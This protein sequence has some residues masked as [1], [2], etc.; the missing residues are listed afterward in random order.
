MKIK[1]TRL[2]SL[3]FIG[4]F[5]INFLW[6]SSVCAQEPE[7][8]D[9]YFV[10]FSHLDFFWGGT[11]EECVSRGNRIISRA[12]QIADKSP[13][14]RF[15]LED[16]VF[17]ENFMSTHKGSPESS[18]FK[19]LVKEGRI[20]ISP[21]WV[22]I[23]QELPDGEVHVRNMT[24]GKRYAKDIFGV[25]TKVAHLGD[26]PGYTPQF[27]QILKQTRVPYA[28]I[29]RMG[30][31]DKSAFTWTSPD[32][33]GVLAWNALNGYP[34]GTFLTSDRTSFEEKK[35][36][37]MNNLAVVKR[38]TSGPVMM[39]WGIDLWAPPVDLVTKVNEFFKQVPARLTIS[40]PS[41][42]FLKLE[43]SPSLPVVSG[44]I[45]SSWPNIVSSLV[46]IWPLIIP[47]TNTLLAAEKFATINYS[48]GYAEYPQKDFDFLWK[49]LVEA[50]DHNHDGQGGT[51]GDNRKIEYLQ[52][53]MIQGGEILRNSLRNIAERV[54]IPVENSFPVVVFNPMGWKRSDIVNAHI[55][56]YGDVEPSD[57]GNFR[58]GIRLLDESGNS[59]PFY[60]KEWSENISR[61][62]EIVFVAADVPSVGYKTFYV[63]ST[64]KP[65]EFARNTVIKLD[66]DND[67]REPRRALGRDI[68]ENNFYRLTVDRAT[69]QVALFDKELNRDVC[70]GMELVALEERG[71]NYIGKEPPSGRTFINLINDITV[72]ENNP[73]RTII[74]IKGT[75]ADI[76]VTQN[77]ALYNNLKRLDI[78]NIVDWKASNSRFV[79]LRQVFPVG[80]ENAKINYGIP[81]GANSADNLMLNAETKRDDEITNESW[82]S[83]RLIH[84]WIHAGT[85]SEGL[86]ISSDHQQIRLGDNVIYAEMVRGTRYVS[87]KV[88]TDEILSSR[89]YPPEGVY[90]FHYSLSSGKGDWKAIKAYR[91]GMNF[92][93][94]LIPISVAD[95]L[96]GK[97]LPPSYSFCSVQQDNIIIST[98]KKADFNSSPVLRLYEIEGADVN[99]AVNFL[100]SQVSFSEV[101]MLEE[102][103]G[104]TSGKILSAKP[105]SISTIRLNIAKKK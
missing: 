7:K 104:R 10:P 2:L 1:S 89:N 70:N 37:F 54:Q 22:G 91:S 20:E 28:V 52:L 30:P 40:T 26:L 86:T 32:G 48:L 92:T 24:I 47:A 80:W 9:I 66:S 39:H 71:G 25:D 38:T 53:S 62:M 29:T 57:L 13:E 83:S 61:A 6:N 105:Y 36:R 100:N 72:T 44:E 14:F 60:V 77:L 42:F 88:S 49:K 43:K 96:S 84:D 79:R 34:W 103:L 87:V 33:S 35:E 12:I 102:D 21:K 63:V 58:K 17:V 98:V 65:E 81:F 3:F 27:P 78:E 69:G 68:I 59:V 90:I 94:H 50:M 73:V 41:E 19:R 51:I 15:L 93:N 31:A 5:I 55:T 67:R 75:V 56:L 18:E 8:T 74:R 82:R 85:D 97:S 4:L 101:N 45:P 16:N 64:D 46:H 76:P 23:F 11:R 95:D 99:T